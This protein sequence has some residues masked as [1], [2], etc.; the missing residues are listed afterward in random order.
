MTSK[1]MDQAYVV[2]DYENG[3][4]GMVEIPFFM[5]MESYHSRN[6]GVQGTE[7]RIEVRNSER[8]I[9]RVIQVNGTKL[10]VDEPW[11]PLVGFSGLYQLRRRAAGGRI[12]NHGEVRG[13]S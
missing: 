5:V 4:K 12:I 1:I 11:R 6:M 8:D 13:T 7:G 10:D 9:I 2:T 3:A